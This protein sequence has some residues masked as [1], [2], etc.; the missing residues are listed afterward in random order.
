MGNANARIEL[1]VQKKT[2]FVSCWVFRPNRTELYWPH[3]F[4][5]SHQW[6]RLFSDSNA[7]GFNMGIITHISVPAAVYSY[8]FWVP[9]FPPISFIKTF[10]SCLYRNLPTQVSVKALGAPAF[11]ILVGPVAPQRQ[12]AT[13]FIWHIAWRC[14]KYRHAFT[15]RRLCQSFS[16]LS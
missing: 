4:K 8:L 6:L 15:W 2:F 14:Q 10:E 5:Y 11:S 13:L 3:V 9:F 7:N 1:I 16:P 12:A